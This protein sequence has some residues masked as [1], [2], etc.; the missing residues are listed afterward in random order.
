M[1][2]ELPKMIGVKREP[3]AAVSGRHSPKGVAGGAGISRFTSVIRM[4]LD[5]AASQHRRM[6]SNDTLLEAARI[7]IARAIRSRFAPGP[8]RD[9]QLEWLTRLGPD[10]SAPPP[11]GG[12]PARPAAVEPPG[13]R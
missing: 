9:R 8:E 13:P 10:N 7:T 11:S 2:R 6:D 5:N 3:H 1:Y 12:E 4:S